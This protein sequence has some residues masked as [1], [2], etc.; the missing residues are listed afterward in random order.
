MTAFKWLQVYSFRGT[1]SQKR[2]MLILSTSFFTHII[3]HLNLTKGSHCSKDKVQTYK[4]P[5]GQTLLTSLAS[6]CPLAPLSTSSHPIFFLTGR[7]LAL[8]PQFLTRPYLCPSYGLSCQLSN[9]RRTY[10]MVV[11]QFTG[12]CLLHIPECQL[13]EDRNHL[14]L[15]FA[16]TMMD[17]KY[18]SKWMMGVIG[19]NIW[20][21]TL[22][23]S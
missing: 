17:T 5:K 15:I 10:M 22:T 19:Q 8:I 2:Q 14:W 21:A 7:G 4:G 1:K 9:H 13:P 11:K 23:S 20:A 3:H 12:G 6:H 18:L 16:K